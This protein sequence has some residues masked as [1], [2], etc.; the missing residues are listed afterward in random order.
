MLK[1]DAR[2]HFEMPVTV[3]TRA[4]RGTFTV[5]FMA[6]PD[7]ELEQLQARADQ[8]PKHWLHAVVARFQDVEIAGELIDGSTD[9]GLQRLLSWP[10]IGPAMV[11]AYFRGLWEEAEKNSEPSPAG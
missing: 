3:A 8:N 2:P 5:T 9:D 11:N 6:M 1:I 4:I 10:G 7:H